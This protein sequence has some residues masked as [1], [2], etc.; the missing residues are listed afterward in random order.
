[1][2]AVLAVVMTRFFIGDLENQA[3]GGDAAGILSNF[4]VHPG[5]YTFA[6][7]VLVA[8]GAAVSLIGSGIAVSRFLKV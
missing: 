2:G 5:D 6:W 7:L 8:A 3:Q 1:L 4:N